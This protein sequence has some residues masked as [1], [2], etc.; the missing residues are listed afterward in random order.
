MNALDF[1][2]RLLIAN[3][4]YGI[5]S[6]ALLIF[7]SA[8]IFAF[9]R[10][11]HVMLVVKAIGTFFLVAVTSQVTLHAWGTKPDGLTVWFY[12]LFS[13]FF[14]LLNYSRN[15]RDG[16]R[17]ELQRLDTFESFSYQMQIENER[18]FET[19]I[20]WGSVALYFGC[21]LVPAIGTNVVTEV[22]FQLLN[23]IDKLPVFGWAIKGLALF[24]LIGLAGEVAFMGLLLSSMLRSQQ[25]HKGATTQTIDVTP[26]Q[27]SLVKE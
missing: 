17:N 8:V 13:A 26:Q 12:P 7:P 25:K 3:Y 10:I 14:L 19:A 1:L 4:V 6:F 15:L 24:N 5:V 21:L 22:F 18:P 11:P 27:V 16:Q 20:M 2:I 9:V 23:W